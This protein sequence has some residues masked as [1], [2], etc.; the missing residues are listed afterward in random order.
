MSAD[1]AGDL[2]KQLRQIYIYDVPPDIL[3]TLVR[4]GGKGQLSSD[5]QA[6]DDGGA[7]SESDDGSDEEEQNVRAGDYSYRAA[8]DE[9]IA[10]VKPAGS[11]VDWY[12]SP[13]IKDIK[14]GAYNIMLP[15]ATSNLHN[16][17]IAHTARSSGE[18]VSQTDERIVAV[19]MAGGGHFAGAIISI[20]GSSRQKCKLLHSKGFHRYTTRRKQGGAQSANDNAKGAANSA[21]AQIRRQQEAM[22]RTEVADLFKEWRLFLDRAELILVRASGVSSRKLMFD[23]GLSRTD[24]KIRRIPITTKRA[25]QAEIVRC[26][27]VLTTLQVEAVDEDG[28]NVSTQPQPRKEPVRPQSSTAEE[29]PPDPRIVE[30]TTKL[31]AAIRRSKVPAVRNYLAEHSIETATFHL[32][33]QKS[34]GHTPTLLHFAAANASAVIVTA[35]LDAGASPQVQNASEKTAF[36]VAEDR[37]VKEAFRLWR[38]RPGNELRWDWDLA[39]V[40]AALTQ[41]QLD[42][43]RARE[44]EELRVEQEAE[45]ARRKLELQR[46]DEEAAENRE[47]EQRAQDRK[48][49]PGR[50]LQHGVMSQTAASISS[51]LEG[52]D[53]ETRKKVERERRARAAEARFAKK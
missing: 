42:V 44:A 32:E 14:V 27:R 47:R 30:H 33:P 52:L 38:G 7:S 1:P 40:P 53:P 9:E 31:V 25:T 45:T 16:V 48:R 12:T 19:F 8:D 36:E 35:L 11:S 41:E 49:G 24:P 15:T 22:L 10:S 43:R 4:T 23:N 28:V 5:T 29:A 26:F 37:D 20:D 6:Q 34:Y 51:S 2:V 50:S 3:S 17:Q 46:L 39:R 18:A 21:G 13:K